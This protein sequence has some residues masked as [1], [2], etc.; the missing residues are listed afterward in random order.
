VGGLSGKANVAMGISCWFRAFRIAELLPYQ[1]IGNLPGV[2]LTHRFHGRSTKIKSN[3][4]NAK[5]GGRSRQRPT[6]R[7]GTILSGYSRGETLTTSE[8]AKG[9]PCLLTRCRA[10][11]SIGRGIDLLPRLRMEAAGCRDEK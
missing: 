8:T 2:P 1:A 11:V 3:V 7:A 5:T 6:R 9:R 4:P 10:T